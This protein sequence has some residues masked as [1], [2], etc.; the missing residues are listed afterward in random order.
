MHMHKHTHRHTDTNFA[1]KRISKTRPASVIRVGG[2][3]VFSYCYNISFK[4]VK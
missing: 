3:P 1:D 2:I 4:P